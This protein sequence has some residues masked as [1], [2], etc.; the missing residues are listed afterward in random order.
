[1]STNATPSPLTGYYKGKGDAP[2]ALMQMVSQGRALAKMERN[3]W[4]QNRFMYRGEQWMRARPGA[5]FSSGRLELLMDTPRGR[6]RDTFN[7]LRQMTDGR[8]SLLTAQRPPYEVIPLSREQNS[9]DA[10]RQASKLIASKWDEKGWN[11]GGAIRDMVL[12]GEID[13]VSYLHVFFDPDCGDVSHIPFTAEGQPVS[14]REQFEALSQQDPEGKTLWQYRPM[15]LGEVS[16]RVVRPGAISVDPS[17]QKWIDCRWIIESRVFPRSVVEQ[18]IGRKVDDILKES[19]ERGASSGSS[20]MQRA[21]IA[22][23]INLEDDGTATGRVVPGRDEFLVHEAYIKPGSEWPKGAHIRWLDR[24]PNVPILIEDYMEYSLP[25]RPFNPKPDGGHFVRCRGTVDELRP[26]QTRFNRILSLLH[27]WLERVARPPMIVPIGSV[28]NQEIYNDK[29]IIEVH[30][31]GD[32]HFMPTPSEPVAMLTQHLQWCVQQMAE[33]ANQSD[34]VRG[35]SPGQGVES[36]I[37]IQ[38]LAQNSETQLSGTASQVATAIEWGLSR[39][40]KLVS[41]NYV[42]PRLISSAGVDDTSELRA[43]VGSQIKGAEDVRITASILPKSRALQ[44]Q[45]LMQLAPLVGQD[46]RPHVARFVE[47][48]YDEFITGE[49]AQR[50][51]QKREN[52]SIAAL[53]QFPQKDQVYQDFLGLQ[54]KYMEAVQV[55]VSQGQDPMQ[56]LGA[57]GINP[58]QILNM[59]RDAGVQIPMVED[60]DDHAQHLRTL[61]DWRLS[62]GFDAVHPMVKQA[63]REHAEQHKKMLTQTLT[64]I[65]QQMPQPDQQNAG[66]SQ[67]APKGQPSPPKNQG[68]AGGQTTMP[69]AGAN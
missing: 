37:G 52:S 8:V 42:M 1:M 19:S 20:A 3:R 66:G 21:D 35:F 49:L 67:P 23:P 26:I 57:A 60:Y 27:E 24:A 6:R 58:P 50:N 17:A 29:G 61:D 62:D 12:N 31:I 41:K 14:S 2:G 22:A 53:A 44:F 69:I 47:G 64:S 43:F 54:S 25:F 10:A 48:S 18:Q 40:L 33:I 11:V 5:G 38:T 34:A 65:G 7:R 30:P 56:M 28:R 16:W 32:P 39:S 46:I 4:Q 15:K 9:I 13:G 63:A 59:L 68:G 51:R 36:A 55:A 45:T